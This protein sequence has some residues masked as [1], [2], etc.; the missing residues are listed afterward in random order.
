MA[1][2]ASR[3]LTCSIE[4]SKSCFWIPLPFCYIIDLPLREADKY[5]RG[6]RLLNRSQGRRPK[7]ARLECASEPATE[8]SQQGVVVGGSL[9]PKR[10]T[11]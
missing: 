7:K 5:K 4:V 10:P 3:F 6:I 11:I 2:A 8:A 9:P 1:L